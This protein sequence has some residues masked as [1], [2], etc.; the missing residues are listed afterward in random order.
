VK[1]RAASLLLAAAAT[2]SACSGDLPR[3]SLVAGVRILA[4][5]AD[6]PYAMPGETVSLR[7]LAA[8]GRADRSRPM[9]LHWLPAPCVNPPGDE[10]F[11]CYPTFA[12]QFAPGV[13]IGS[14]LASGD[15][16]SFTMPSDAIASAAPHPGASDPYG[17]AFAFV[18]ACAGHVEYVPID[19]RAAS[20]VTTPFG[21]FDDAGTPLDATQFVFAFTRVYAYADRRNANPA[22]DHLTFG[23][24]PVDPAAGIALDHCAGSDEPSCKT[25]DVDAVVPDTSWEIDP[26]TVDRAGSP[27]H[28]AVWVDYYATG[29][30]FANDSVVL[31]DAT[32]GRASSTADGYAAPLT[33][34]P[35]TL[36][37]VVHDTRGGAS[38]VAVPLD[39]R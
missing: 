33:A 21:C 30:R 34:G 12:S 14:A 29:G 13:D 15:H 39:A 23:G 16:W 9:Q 17:V 20:P 5:S 24:T 22:I 11:A 28:E 38:W 8:D 6:A 3:A 19:P 35:A 37:A 7:V 26:G 2:C 31:F 1:T 4:T 10:Y 27:G 25:T 18:L 36:W 32:S